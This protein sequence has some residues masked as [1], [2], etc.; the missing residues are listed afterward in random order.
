MAETVELGLQR[1][2]RGLG[3]AHHTGLDSIVAPDLG[4]VDVDLD[5]AVGQ[6]Q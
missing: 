4:R 6:S 5:D 2:Q 1:D 3:V